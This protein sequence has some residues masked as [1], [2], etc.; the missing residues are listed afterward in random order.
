M[1]FIDSAIHSYVKRVHMSLNRETINA[2]LGYVDEGAAAYMTKKWDSQLGVTYQIALNQTCENFSALDGTILTHKALGPERALL[3]RI[4]THILMPQSGSYHR[5]TVSDTLVL[6]DIITSS[7]I[8]FAYLMVRHMWECVRS[9]KKANLPYG[10]FLTCIFEYFNV[11]L[12]NEDVENK[13]STIKGGGVSGSMKGNKRK[14]SVPTA[15]SDSDLESRPAEPAKVAESIKE[16]L[17]E[18]SN[19]SKLMVQ[20]YKAARK[21]AYENEKVWTKCKKE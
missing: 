2:A 17:T 21:Q 10:I 4:I 18:F 12:T 13:V 5:V 8:S 16:V 6:F 20:S 3:H 11:D 9:N 7:P 15:Y 14:C 19:M 1:S